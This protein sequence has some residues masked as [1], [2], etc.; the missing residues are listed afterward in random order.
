[1]LLKAPLVLGCSLLGH[2]LQRVTRI[3]VSH[4]SLPARQ[5]LAHR[6]GQAPIY[7]FLSNASIAI[8]QPEIHHSIT[9][10]AH[11]FKDHTRFRVAKPRREGATHHCEPSSRT[12][13]STSPRLFLNTKLG[14]NLSPIALSGCSGIS[15]T[16]ISACK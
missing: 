16:I 6:K 15:P 9:N 1:M 8:H 10:T 14:F 12:S 11:Y 2:G 7:S 13:R 5:I 4:C 3:G